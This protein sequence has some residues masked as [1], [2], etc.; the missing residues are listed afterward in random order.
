MA[1]RID[2]DAARVARR[3]AA[4]EGPVV[5]IG[6]EDLPLAAEVPFEV[7]ELITLMALNESKEDVEQ[8]PAEQAADQSEQTA[9]VTAV[10][11]AL[12][13]EHYE[14]FKAQRPSVQDYTFLMEGVM[15]SYGFASTGE[16]QDSASPS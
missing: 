11:K 6:G 8:T 5:V 7:V 12:L 9:R 1:E 15:R 16:S 10:V 14:K 2:L 13:G 4:G 3:E